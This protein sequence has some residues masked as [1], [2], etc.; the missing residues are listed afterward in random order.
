M[1]A[2]VVACIAA[3]AGAY[4]FGE[5]RGG[6][7]RL[8]AHRQIVRLTQARDVL[9]RKNADLRQQ[10]VFL[11]RSRDIDRTAQA[12][13]RKSNETL[14]AQVVKLRKQLSFYHDIVAPGD[15][16]AHAGVRVQALKL[17]SADTPGRYHYSMVLMQAPRHNRTTAGTVKMTV[18]GKRDKAQL[19]LDLRAL[20]GGKSD[21]RSFKFRYF[22]NLQGELEL[23]AGFSP[24][25]VE[26]TVTQN[27]RNS[28]PFTR[29]FD[30]RV[31]G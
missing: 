29:S 5:W 3:V 18:V 31:T 1:A 8:A 11:K 17:T 9:A 16:A 7:E 28:D 15:D 26:I 27:G 13:V 2:A 12:H 22:E 14:Q 24:E 30:W 4:F 19:A 21:S 25:R 10:A 20:G 23:P 6:Y